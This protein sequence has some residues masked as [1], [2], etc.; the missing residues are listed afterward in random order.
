MK[1]ELN[2]NIYLVGKY[3]DA[4]L[5]INPSQDSNYD[6]IIYMR[7]QIEESITISSL[8]GMFVSDEDLKGVFGLE[9]GLCRR[10]QVK[11]FEKLYKG[12]FYFF[13]ESKNIPPGN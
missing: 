7:P 10:D 5:E 3:Y 9:D 12:K 8:E 1:I 2:K 13:D 11:E 4:S 6:L